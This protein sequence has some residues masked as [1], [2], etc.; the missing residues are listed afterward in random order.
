MPEDP[1][2]DNSPGVTTLRQPFDTGDPATSQWTDLSKRLSRRSGVPEAEVAAWTAEALAEF[3]DVPIRAYVPVL[4]EHMIRSRI[5][6]TCV[7]RAAGPQGTR[8]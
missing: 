8:D 2:S 4:V 5:A 6:A 3:L 7:D 1:A